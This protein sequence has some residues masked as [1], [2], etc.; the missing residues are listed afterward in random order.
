MLDVNLAPEDGAELVARHAAVATMATAH[1][2]LAAAAAIGL[3]APLH[4]PG[5]QAWRGA[6]ASRSRSRSIR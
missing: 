5:A 6:A 4:I 1:A 2:V 3:S